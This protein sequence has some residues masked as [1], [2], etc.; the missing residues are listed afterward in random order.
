MKK[1]GNNEIFN[2][3][4]SAV[5]GGAFFAIPYLA[6]DVSILPSLGMGVLAFGAG[7][8]LFSNKA[9]K[10][11]K[12]ATSTN[13]N[14]YNVLNKA[15]MDNAKI[16]SMI[17]KIEDKDLRKDIEELHETTSKIIDTIS[18]KPEKLSKATTFFDYYLPVTLKILTK[19]DDIENQ[20]LDNEEVVK[21]MKNTENMI[22]KIKN[23]FKSQLANLYQ[24]DIIDTD[25]EIK[26]F[27]QMLNA[28]GFNDIND[29]DIK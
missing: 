20:K 6:L 27:D 26:V 9:S 29:F 24:S 19:Y 3:I 7:N 5:L 23:A 10:E 8:L 13:T 11:K 28:E 16:Y 25:A 1:E 4:I 2:G 12:V 22:S 21:F 14:L 18:K 15:K 17:N